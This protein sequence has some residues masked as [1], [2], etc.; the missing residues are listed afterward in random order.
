MIKYKSISIAR[1]IHLTMPLP[2]SWR[3]VLSTRTKFYF[4]GMFS[5][6]SI[7]KVK[8]LKC[9]PSVFVFTLYIDRL[10]YPTLY[11]SD[12]LVTF[13]ACWYVMTINILCLIWGTLLVSDIYPNLLI[14]PNIFTTINTGTDIEHSRSDFKLSFYKINVS[15]TQ[16]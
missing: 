12:S 5:L 7:R 16:G 10:S 14:Y 15:N 8:Y 2:L 11:C 9:F 4:K 1:C 6:S 13:F 3:N